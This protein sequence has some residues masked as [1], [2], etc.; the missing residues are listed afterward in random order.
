MFLFCLSARLH[1]KSRPSGTFLIS[2]TLSSTS[3]CKTLTCTELTSWVLP[4]QWLF[5]LR[6]TASHRTQGLLQSNTLIDW[7]IRERRLRAANFHKHDG[8]GIKT[9][10]RLALTLKGKGIQTGSDRK[11]RGWCPFVSH[12]VLG[13]TR[14][15]IKDIWS[16]WLTAQFTRSKAFWE[17]LKESCLQISRLVTLLG[18]RV[19][20][21][22]APALVL[23]PL[24][25]QSSAAS[26][27]IQLWPPS[28]RS[29][30]QAA[31]SEAGC[32]E[33][34]AGCLERLR[35]VKFDCRWHLKPWRRSRRTTCVRRVW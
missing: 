35:F 6:V 3:K 1:S 25:D 31:A 5:R 7:T 33:K 10:P 34:L 32:E 28:A 4:V 24:A 20:L 11:Q 13:D 17:I 19:S 30:G 23:F 15:D 2:E 22:N 12:H 21:V 16:T 9:A 26:A 29:D 18:D 27:S 14:R 8:S